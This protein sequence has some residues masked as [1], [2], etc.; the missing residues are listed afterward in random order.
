MK[1]KTF[2]SASLAL[3]AVLTLATS[4]VEAAILNAYYDPANGNIKLQNTT[5]GTQSFLSFSVLTLGNGTYG[6]ASGL[7]G[8][9]GYLSTGSA[10]LPASA[11]PTSNFSAG[12]VNGLYSEAGASNIGSPA[13]MTL[14][15]YAGWSTGSPI[16]PV[17]SYWDLGNI[18]VTGMTQ[19]DLNTRFLTPSDLSPGGVDLYGQ[20]LF[21]YQT[22]PGVFSSTTPGDVLAVVPEPST[23]AIVAAAAGFGGFGAVSRRRKKAA[24]NARSLSLNA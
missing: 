24:A 1:T 9:V 10:T 11:F 13:I 8:N 18:A 12:G 6:A 7:P 21:S 2:F 16:G 20:F 5:S 4:A 17:G 15:P 14:A 23:L 19:A 22:S 3:A